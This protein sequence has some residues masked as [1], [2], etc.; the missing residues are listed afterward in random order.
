MPQWIVHACDV[1]WFYQG[2]FRVDEL[3]CCQKWGLAAY[4]SKAIK[5]A[6][7]VES[8]LHFC[9]RHLVG[10]SGRADICPKVDHP[11]PNNYGASAFIDRGTGLHAEAAELALISI[12]TLVIG[13]GLIS[14]I[15][16]VLDTVYLKFQDHFFFFPFLWGQFSEL[17]QLMSW[18]Q[19]GDYNFSTWWH[20][21][22]L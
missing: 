16:V 7:L 12:L 2:I 22:Y 14:I 19:P 8:L 11:P 18:L 1:L 15:L 5:E 21:Q 9:C 4:C 10:G 6:R 13:G 3:E 17:W 20:F